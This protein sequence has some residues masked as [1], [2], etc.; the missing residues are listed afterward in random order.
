MEK[1][2]NDKQLFLMEYSDNEITCRSCDKRSKK[3]NQLVCDYCDKHYCRP[4]SF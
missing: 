2:S 4:E 3:E 1:E